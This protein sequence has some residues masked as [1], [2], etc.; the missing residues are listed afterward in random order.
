MEIVTVKE[1]IAALSSVFGEGSVSRNGKNLSVFCPICAR[2]PKTKKKRKL[3][4]CLDSGIYH[5]WIC[6]TKGKNI[7]Y[8]AKKENGKIECLSLLYKAFGK[9]G[10]ESVEEKIIKLPSDFRL[11][12]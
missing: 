9:K 7:A 6:E 4:I 2:S 5:C 10:K 11:L 12:C 1:K 8:F 3:S